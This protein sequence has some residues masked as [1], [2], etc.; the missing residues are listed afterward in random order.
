ML[1]LSDRNKS[2]SPGS[3]SGEN[4]DIRNSFASEGY[5]SITEIANDVS[6]GEIL[7]SYG[8]RLDDTNRKMACPFKSHKGGRENTP[9][10]YFY[11]ETNTYC[12]FGCRQGS[13]PVDFVSNIE[14]ISKFL[15]AKKIIDKFEKNIDGEEFL[16]TKEN[17][18]ERMNILLEYSNAVRNFR[19]N[20]NDDKSFKFIE[21]NC[22]SFDTIIKK[23]ALDNAALKRVV[24]ILI[25]NIN[26]YKD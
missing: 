10:F 23:H 26:K 11:P 21:N 2:D 5:Q 8:F 4:G 16:S 9:S 7:R 19:F 3:P 12:C 18:S 17:H 14:N 13:K 1:K 25:E 24:N 15:A 20:F 22:L 6:L